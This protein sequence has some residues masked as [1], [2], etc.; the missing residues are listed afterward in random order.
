VNADTFSAMHEA[1]IE[2]TE[3]GRVAADDGWF[4]LNLADMEW[5]AVEGGGTWSVFESPQAPSKTLGIGVHVLWPGDT[6]GMY[7]AESD[8]EGFLVLSGEC[9]AVVE[10]QERRMGPWDYFHCPAGTAHITVGAGDGPCAIVMVGAR[11]PDHATRYIPDPAAARHGAA[12]ETETGSSRE[13]YADRP[14]LR[15]VRSPWPLA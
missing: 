6:P 10:G 4:I 12:V 13:A 5:G 2:D 7:H 3:Y 9:V 8:Q 1:R 11:S 14:P 15:R